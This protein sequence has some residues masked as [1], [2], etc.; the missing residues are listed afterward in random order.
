MKP[1]HAGALKFAA[2]VGFLA[3]SACSPMMEGARPDPVDLSHFVVGEPRF[4]ISEQLGSPTATVKD[5]DKWCDVYQ[6]YTSGPGTSTKDAIGVGEFWADVLTLGLAEVVFT[7]IE[8]ATRNSKH[9]VFMCYDKDYK[10]AV[11]KESDTPPS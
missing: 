5:G 9:T 6:L 2:L 11:C 8:T 10:L 4:Q 1:S 3:L 7:P